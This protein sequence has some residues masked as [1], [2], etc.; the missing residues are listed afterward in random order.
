MKTCTL[1][2]LPR[3]DTDSPP[4]ALAILQSICDKNNVESSLLDFNIVLFNSLT[5]IEWNL[6]DDWCMFLKKDIPQ[7]LKDKIVHLWEEQ[8]TKYNIAKKDIVG[9]S[10]F[11]YYS[12]PIAKLLLPILK[13]HVQGIVVLGGNGC[14]SKFL[15]SNVY[16]DEWIYKNQHADFIVYGDG[17]PGFDSILKNKFEGNGINNKNSVQEYDLDQFPMPSYKNFNFDDYTSDKIYIT[18]SRGCV[19]KCTFCDIA[20]IWPTFRYR[21][22]ENL[23]EEIKQQF[24]SHGITLFDFTDSLINGSQSNFYKFNCLLAEEKE[25]HPELKPISYIGQAICK[26]KTQ[27]PDHHFEAMYYGGCKQM[28]IGL[29][30]FSEPV[31]SHMKKK[32]SNEDID[33]H[34]QKCSEW[35]IDNVFLMITGYPTETL[36]DHNDNV[37]GLYKYQKYAMNGTI[38]MIRWGYTMHL[39]S[40]TPITRP[41]M[42]KHLKI[43]ADHRY[44]DLPE[45]ATLEHNT[46][47]ENIDLVDYPYTWISDLNPTLD[48]K[49]RIRRRVELHEITCKLKYLQPNVH[50]ELE[51]VYKLS[52]QLTKK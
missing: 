51:T 20:N 47:Q 50:A 12:L 3:Y 1:I 25:K 9:V 23:V 41:H 17:E 19:R 42:L 11:S 14:T 8:I 4:A 2:N 45:V 48:L 35:N 5:T 6:L 15:G 13:K 37:Q 44:Q 22:A 32:F 49:E 36:Q 7:L 21:S 18:G 31:R 40:D 43:H 39:Y 30:S 52:Q 24:Y 27:T 16:F 29:E 28:T 34:L 10:I 46:R 26:P 33:Y 38:S